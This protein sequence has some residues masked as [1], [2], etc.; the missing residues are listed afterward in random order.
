M[1][2]KYL[3]GLVRFFYT[4]RTYQYPDVEIHSLGA[5]RICSYKKSHDLYVTPKLEVDVKPNALARTC[6]L[7]AQLYINKSADGEFFGLKFANSH[8]ELNKIINKFGYPKDEWKRGSPRIPS[9]LFYKLIPGFYAKIRLPLQKEPVKFDIVNVSLSG[10]GLST[11]MENH[12]FFVLGEEIICNLTGDT[13]ERELLLKVRLMNMTIYANKGK[14]G[15]TEEVLH[16]GMKFTGF[17]EASKEYFFK[18]IKKTVQ[19]IPA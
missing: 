13:M 18:L 3:E 19:Q 15:N 11:T 9:S 6:K 2:L 1:E 4:N 14:N 17:E 10:I 16:L 12:D 7:I 8:K 5:P